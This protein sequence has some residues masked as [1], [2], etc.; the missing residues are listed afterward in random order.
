[1]KNNRLILLTFVSIISAESTGTKSQKRAPNGSMTEAD[2]LRA[3]WRQES[4]EREVVERDIMQLNAGYGGTGVPG[5]T[6]GGI[7]HLAGTG[8]Q[9]ASYLHQL[10]LEALVQQRRQETLAQLAFAQEMELNPQMLPYVQA[11]QL[12]RAALWRQE[13]MLQGGLAGISH[14]AW[15]QPLSGLGERDV[16]SQREV[17]EERLRKERYEQQQQLASLGYGAGRNPGLIAALANKGRPEPVPSHVQSTPVLK[18]I[19]APQPEIVM[20]NENEAVRTSGNMP[21]PKSNLKKPQNH[22]QQTAINADFVLAQL[23][24]RGV[25]EIALSATGVSMPPDRKA[26]IEERKCFDSR[27]EQWDKLLQSRPKSTENIVEWVRQVLAVS[28][29]DAELPVVQ[30]VETSNPSLTK[31]GSESVRKVVKKRALP[32][33]GSK[34]KR[35]YKK[36]SLTI[37]QKDES[38]PF[39]DTC[40]EPLADTPSI[41]SPEK[42]ENEL[43]RDDGSSEE[44]KRNSTQELGLNVRDGSSPDLTVP[45][46]TTA[47]LTSGSVESTKPE[48][49]SPARKIEKPPDEGLSYDSDSGSSST[50]D[51]SVDL[52]ATKR[53]NHVISST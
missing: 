41:S 44:C 16:T 37:N 31:K 23:V 4:L 5:N 2:Y 35:P 24:E 14:L 26:N 39:Q 10:R 40:R 52:R 50:S 12:R 53:G 27:R 36:S 42:I 49:D 20:N 43:R 9:E 1:M 28:D 19:Q 13:L 3:A 30:L 38:S 8:T 11:E 17:H 47:Y 33:N 45:R 29:I 48:I 7:G 51:D 32:I 15:G 22:E 21:M 34:S 18:H 25:K 46:I 6:G